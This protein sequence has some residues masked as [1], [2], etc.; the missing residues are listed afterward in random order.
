MQIITQ[1]GLRWI[2][3]AIAV[4]VLDQ[5]TKLAILDSF[6]LHERVNYTS[7][8]NLVYVRSVETADDFLHPEEPDLSSRLK[9]LLQNE[10]CHLYFCRAVVVIIGLLHQ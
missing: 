9:T 4:L 7:F 3:I 8:F 2:W 10:R 6:I 5:V 1:T